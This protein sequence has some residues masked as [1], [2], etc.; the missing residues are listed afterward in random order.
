MA[1]T[2]NSRPLSLI[3]ALSIACAVI[4]QGCRRAEQIQSYDV[5]KVTAAA[6]V[7]MKSGDAT[8]RML[9]A[10]FPAGEQAWVFKAVGPIPEVDKHE[11]EIRDFFA[12]VTLGEDG[13]AH[14]KLPAGWREEPGN[15]VRLATI[16]IPGDK[17]LEITVNVVPSPNSEE[18]LLANVNRWRGQMQLSAI[19][20]DQLNQMAHLVKAGEKEILVVDLKGRYKTGGM[21]PPFAGGPFTTSGRPPKSSNPVL[22]E[23][24]PPIDDENTKL[25][26][27]LPA[28]HPPIDSPMPPSDIA[29]A[30]DSPKVEAPK[31]VA[32]ASWKEVPATGIRKADFLIADGKQQAE[33]TLIEFPAT[34]GPMIADPLLNINRWRREIGM[35]EVNKDALAGAT[36]SIT[37]DGHPATFAAM[38]PDAKKSDQANSGLASLAAMVRDGDQ[39][40]FIKMIGSRELVAGRKDE[41]KT[42]LKSIKFPQKG[43]A[44]HGNK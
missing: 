20:L 19:E 2:W 1:L 21:T 39:M 7:E 37:I 22:P 27:G 8:D 43:G 10:M 40:W 12:A 42:F 36:E 30:S 25:P 16:V 13:K 3:F 14:W 33:V 4:A 41:F 18:N 38:I 29:S 26:A 24:H 15:P 17:R 35:D 32:P 6:S 31:F 44:V 28:G 9:T 5:P 34:E 23:G 11:K